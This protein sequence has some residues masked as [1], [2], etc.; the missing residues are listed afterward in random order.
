MNRAEEF[1]FVE[2]GQYTRF[3]EFC[4]ACCRDRYI[5]ICH[6]PPGV[7]KTAS[8]RQYAKWNTAEAADVNSAYSHK[9]HE[10]LD[11]HCIFYS[12]QIVNAPKQVQTDIEHLRVRVRMSSP[13]MIKL[14]DRMEPKLNDAVRREKKERKE[15]LENLRSYRTGDFHRFQSK[16]TV[17]EIKEKQGKMA[18]KI[19]DPVRLIIVDEADQLKMSSLEQ[20]RHIFDQGGVGLLL[21]GMPGLEKRLA[22]YAQLYS[23]VGFVHAFRPLPHAETR[24]LLQKNLRLINSALPAE[25]LTEE[26][27]AMIIRVTGGNFRLLQRLLKQIGRLLEIN[28]LESVNL[29]VVEAAREN[30]VIGTD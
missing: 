12:A 14:Q 13:P 8:A 4:D 30:L 6:G 19:E 16:P 2:T 15:F 17:S 23:R 25:T 24:T 22:R 20:I 10:P 29:D 28:E 9:Y 3:H 5:G 21:I 11:T 18:E 7:G 27:V 1:Q 26:V